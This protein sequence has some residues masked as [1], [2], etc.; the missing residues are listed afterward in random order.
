MFW[1]LK[2]DLGKDKESY[3]AQLFVKNGSEIL[4][5][6]NLSFSYQS[7]VHSKFK[8]VDFSADSKKA[9]AMITLKSSTDLSPGLRSV[10]IPEPNV[11]NLN[12]KL[13][14]GN[15]VVYSESQEN[16]FN[17]RLFIGHR[18]SNLIR[19]PSL[20]FFFYLFKPF[21]PKPFSVY[22]RIQGLTVIYTHYN[23]KSSFNSTI[24]QYYCQQV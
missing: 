7:P 14:S 15:E 8:L 19:H 22:M 11:I 3:I 1:G 10:Q 12:L 2:E 4:D 17:C 5:S 16:I 20:F 18:L 6:R 24:F 21:V 23:F 9:F 13:L